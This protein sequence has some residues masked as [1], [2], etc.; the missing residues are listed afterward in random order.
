MHD[1]STAIGTVAALFTTFANVPQLKKCWDTG[2]ADDISLLMLL[3][4]TVGLTL[5]VTYG[6]VKDD[7]IIIGSNVVGLLLI[8][9]IVFFKAR[10]LVRQRTNEP[11]SE[12]A[13]RETR[14]RPSLAGACPVCQL[15][16]DLKTCPPV[17]LQ[18]RSI[19]PCRQGN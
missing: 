9:G 8:A 14:S 19:G 17:P 15:T 2:K 5:W 12:E 6:I 1:W 10:N 3:A 4:L 18:L 7:S 16:S 11:A 13:S